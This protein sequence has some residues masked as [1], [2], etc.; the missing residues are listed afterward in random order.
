MNTKLIKITGQTLKELEI[1]SLHQ[2]WKYNKGVF[3]YKALNYAAPEYIPKLYTHPPSRYSN[4]INHDLDLPRP[5]IDIIY[6]N[7]KQA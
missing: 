6:I 4:S 3:M 1:M 7:S 5:R 2:Q